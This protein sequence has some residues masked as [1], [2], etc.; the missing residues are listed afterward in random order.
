[1]G[2][3]SL[4]STRDLYDLA[5]KIMDMYT[6]FDL[7]LKFA[8]MDEDEQM[9]ADFSGIVWELELIIETYGL[10]EMTK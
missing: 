10:R 4:F 7:L 6:K 3:K 5:D 2:K 9:I 1:M 8:R